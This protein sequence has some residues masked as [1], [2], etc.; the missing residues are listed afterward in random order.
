MQESMFEVPM[1]KKNLVL[2][3]DDIQLRTL[4]IA[5]LGQAG[6]LVRAAQDGFSALALI[7]TEMPDLVLSDLYMTGMSGFELLSVLRRRFPK[8]RV[9]A[10]SSAFTGG[11]VPLGVAADAFYQKATSVLSLLRILE[12]TDGAESSNSRERGP[13][14]A[15]IWIAAEPSQTEGG[16]VVIGCPECLRSFAH[17]PGRTISVV[18]GAICVY[19]LTRIHYAMVKTVDPGPPHRSRR[20]IEMPSP[21][22][23]AGNS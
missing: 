19:C 20:L 12:Q 13:D 2:V 15:P 8:I 17:V 18:R 23:R 21:A 22:Y 6:Y 14:P 11:E 16:P 10:M 3:D 1:S 5:I 7:R 4:L 9:I